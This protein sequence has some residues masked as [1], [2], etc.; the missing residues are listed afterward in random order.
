M[1]RNPR[2]E[3]G[4]G[5]LVLAAAGLLGFMALKVG[6]LRSLG[7]QVRLTTRLSDAA[8]LTEGAVVKVAGVDVGRVSGIRLDNRQAVLDLEVRTDAAVPADALVRVRARSVLGEKYVELVL[9]A[10]DAPL[11][12]DGAELASLPPPME[13]DLLV[14]RMAPLMEGLPMEELAQTLKVLNEAVAQD[15]Q[16]MQRILA[17]VEI[18]ARNGALAS[19]A[20]PATVGETRETLRF[21]RARM[22]QARPALAR[23]DTVLANLE[24]G[25]TDLAHTREQADALLEETREAVA[26]GRQLIGLLDQNSARLERILQNAE[27]IDKWEL[28]RLLREEG[29]LVRLRK[30]EVVELENESPTTD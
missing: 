15:P 3:I 19:E 4:V 17:D 21:A 6:A 16:R 10:P 1:A 27:E 29:I 23:A 8:G 2:H 5:L 22:E 9:G 7:D 12:V 14:D 11:A 18:M 13:I 24:A 25:T 26:E 30:S 20:L 28:R